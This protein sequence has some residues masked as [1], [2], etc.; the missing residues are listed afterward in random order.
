LLAPELEQAVTNPQK[1]FGNTAFVYS[2]YL[3]C[4]SLEV[5]QGRKS[6]DLPQD[7]RP[8]I[9]KTYCY[10]NENGAMATWLH[11]L[12]NGTRWRKG[13]RAMSQ[14]ARVTL[15]DVGNTLPESKAQTRYSEVDTYEVLLLSGMVL[16]PDK[17][18]SQL[19]LLSG[20]RLLLPWARNMLGKRDWRRLS[21]T[22]MRQTVSVRVQDA[23]LQLPLDTLNKFGL[24]HCFYLGS[25][26]HEEAILRVVL[27]DEVGDLQGVQGAQVHEKYVLNYRDDLGYRVIKN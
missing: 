20:E 25:P 26:E 1:A 19:T 23:P 11:E 2:P 16:L 13:R 3:L 7:I 9:E 18:A 27:V 4:R 10:R 14:L 22:L 6:V 24:Q 15:A 12:D 5:W 8:L 21:A 17:K